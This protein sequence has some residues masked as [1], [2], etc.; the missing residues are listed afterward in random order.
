MA[1]QIMTNWD[2]IEEMKA[3][4]PGDYLLIVDSVRE[5]IGEKGLRYNFAL[6]I[7]EDPQHDGEHVDEMIFN[8][9]GTS[10]KAMRFAK[11]FFVALKFQPALG[12]ALDPATGEEHYKFDINELN[13]IVGDQTRM[14]WATVKN[15]EYEGN[16]QARA[17]KFWAA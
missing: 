11:P 12:S 7:V 2:D 14:V 4:P 17:T 16:T 8:S 10:P 15:T 3:P 13:S 5:A 6:R 1:D 9:V